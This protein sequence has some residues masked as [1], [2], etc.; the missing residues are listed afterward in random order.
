MADF[1]DAV[2]IGDGEL[3]LLEIADRVAAAKKGGQSRQ[4][5]LRQLAQLPGVYVPQ[6]YQTATD[7]GG[8][9]RAIKPLCKEAGKTTSARIEER[10]LPQNYPQKP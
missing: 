2:V 4:E 8:R 10:L 9:F 7:A 6:F 1:F 5:L 3:L